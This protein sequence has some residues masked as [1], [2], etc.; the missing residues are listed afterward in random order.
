VWRALLEWYSPHARY[1]IAA[2]HYGVVNTPHYDD[3]DDED[4]KMLPELR[5]HALASIISVWSLMT[6]YLVLQHSSDI[7]PIHVAL[8]LGVVQHAAMRA[9]FV[10]FMFS[11]TDRSMEFLYLCVCGSVCSVSILV[12]VL[13]Y[14]SDEVDQYATLM[15]LLA[16]NSTIEWMIVTVACFRT[17]R[18]VVGCRMVEA[19]LEWIAFAA[20]ALSDAHEYALLGLLVGTAVTR[21][22]E[23]V[24]MHGHVPE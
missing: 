18:L 11:A 14:I 8:L 19:V 6:G 2:T 4:I 9:T 22:A 21:V 24:L 13:H 23:V 15:T 3:V 20:Y 5:I 17:F 1:G 12:I 7:I 10:C 16:V